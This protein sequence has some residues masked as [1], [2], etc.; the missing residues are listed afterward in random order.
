MT[1]EPVK[2]DTFPHRA[3]LRKLGGVWYPEARAWFFDDPKTA[4]KARELIKPKTRGKK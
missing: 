4:K 2:G 1:G 3:E